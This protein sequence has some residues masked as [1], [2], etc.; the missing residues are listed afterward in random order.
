MPIPIYTPGGK[1]TSSSIG[2]F[3]NYFGPAPD[4]AT[5]L[6]E[7]AD[8]VGEPCVILNGSDDW[9]CERAGR[10]ELFSHEGLI[11]EQRVVALYHS[12][13][14]GATH[15]GIVIRRADLDGLV[16]VYKEKWVSW[17]AYVGV[18]AL[19]NEGNVVRVSV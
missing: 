13:T 19:D 5:A 17:R 9:G 8:L 16:T 10:P 12:G 14:S 2:R 3:V 18:Y 15:S 1:H 7:C 6:R 11:E 4:K